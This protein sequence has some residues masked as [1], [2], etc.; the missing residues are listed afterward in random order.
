MK[1]IGVWAIFPE[2]GPLVATAI[3]NGDGLRPDVAELIA[4]DKKTRKLEEDPFTSDMTNL[5]ITRIIGLRSRFEVDLNRPRDRAV[6]ISPE[7]AWGI[8][9]WKTNP[10]R[11]LISDSLDEYDLFYNEMFKVLTDLQSRFG[12]FVVLDLHSYNYRREGPKGPPADPGKNPEVNLGTETINRKLWGSLVDRFMND[13]Q[14]FRYDGRYLDVRENIK[15]KGG[16][17]SRWIHENFPFSGCS[18]SVEFKKIFM[19]EWTGVP[20]RSRIDQLRNA[21]KST[22]NGVLEELDKV[23]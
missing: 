6:Y 23:K 2:D 15:F 17:L 3:H 22:I 21:L 10:M 8:K 20:D 5:G 13:L 4:V 7:D 19:D 12:H 18:I 9:V 14:H 11:G 1:N 16:N